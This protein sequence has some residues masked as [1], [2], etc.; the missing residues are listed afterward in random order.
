[1][2]GWQPVPGPSC[3]ESPGQDAAGVSGDAALTGRNLEGGRLQRCVTTEIGRRSTSEL[4]AGS[5]RAIS[6]Q[7]P[8]WLG[9][10]PAA[11]QVCARTGA[12]TQPICGSCPLRRSGFEGVDSRDKSQFRG[13]LLGTTHRPGPRRQ[14]SPGKERG[15]HS[16]TKNGLSP[17][18]QCLDVERP[19][20][21]FSSFVQG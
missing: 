12:T 10:S 3:R 20:E 15:D 7:S 17:V 5:L 16:T 2:P 6:P 1:M 9:A 18:F 11:R 13:H 8:R 4:W 14:F 21:S 19:V